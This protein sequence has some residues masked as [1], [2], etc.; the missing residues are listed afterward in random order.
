MTSE[1]FLSIS[2]GKYVCHHAVLTRDQGYY[3]GARRFTTIGEVVDYFTDHPLGETTL[4][5]ECRTLPKCTSQVQ[6]KQ[7]PDI[8]IPCPPNIATNGQS[9][10]D[11]DSNQR[12]STA[13]T[14]VYSTINQSQSPKI[15][16]TSY[17]PADDKTLTEGDEALRVC[18]ETNKQQLPKNG[19]R[20]DSLAKK[21][22]TRSMAIDRSDSSG[23]FQ[24]T[25]L[26]PLLPTRS[27]AVN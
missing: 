21:A 13:Q 16:L 26:S 2:L 17:L 19:P 25:A 5:Q 11:L 15:T 23:E 20:V 4:K 22:L 12:L 3:V 18:M 9:T 24:E 1:L 7:H 8:T 14:T 6:I 10:S 27:S